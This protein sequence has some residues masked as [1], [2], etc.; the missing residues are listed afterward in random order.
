[1]CIL[2]L[3]GTD[4]IAGVSMFFLLFNGQGAREQGRG[5]RDLRVR[6]QKSLGKGV[7]N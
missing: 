3:Q 7:G 2:Y 1:M 4:M 6:E 5:S